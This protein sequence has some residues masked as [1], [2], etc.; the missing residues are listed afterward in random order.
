MIHTSNAQLQVR[1]SET[2]K[3]WRPINQINVSASIWCDAPNTVKNSDS[4]GVKHSSYF[5]QRWSW[6]GGSGC[7]NGCSD[8][9]PAGELSGWDDFHQVCCGWC[10]WKSLMW[11]DID[12]CY[13]RL[14]GLRSQPPV[15]VPDPP[16]VPRW[17]A[18]E[19]PGLARASPGLCPP[20]EMVRSLETPGWPAALGTGR[21]RCLRPTPWGSS[22][23]PLK[24]RQS[25]AKMSTWLLFQTV[26]GFVYCLLPRGAPCR[27][28]TPW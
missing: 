28:E 20:V 11:G 25:D 6:F 19:E 10:G 15:R 4:A 21:R 8:S 17:A 22:P 23:G 16:E 9:W 5:D 18:L 2:K 3:R 14:P 13:Q 12:T 24:R 7:G 26:P 1:C 27:A